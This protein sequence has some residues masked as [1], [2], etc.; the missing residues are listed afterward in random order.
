MVLLCRL[1]GHRRASEIC[2]ETGDLRSRCTRCAAQLVMYGPKDWRGVDLGPR[3]LSLRWA[4]SSLGQSVR[5]RLSRHRAARGIGRWVNDETGQG[6]HLSHCGH[7][8]VP[9]ARLPGQGWR[10][11]PEAGLG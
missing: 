4:L 11:I 8:E 2:G 6:Y 7:C 1:L 9:L 5:C 10:A 3:R